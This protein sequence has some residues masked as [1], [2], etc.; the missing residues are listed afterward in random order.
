MSLG[1]EFIKENIKA[2]CQSVTLV[3]AG[4]MVD[5]KFTKNGLSACQLVCEAQ[6]QIMIAMPSTKVVLLDNYC[7]QKGLRQPNCVCVFKITLQ[8]HTNI[9][10]VHVIPD[11]TGNVGILYN[12]E[13]H[14]LP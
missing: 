13:G 5:T 2:T 1:K 6:Q 4:K 12:E 3:Q 8:Q 11:E 10:F 7:T 9:G 14:P